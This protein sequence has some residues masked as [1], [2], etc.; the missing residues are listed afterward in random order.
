[1]KPTTLILFACCLVVCDVFASR[2]DFHKVI[3]DIR[4]DTVTND[5]MQEEVIIIDGCNAK[6]RY[7][8]KLKG[9]SFILPVA[10]YNNA[11]F[12]SFNEFDK[13]TV[14]L[15]N[16][17]D[18]SLSVGVGG[19]YNNLY[20]SMQFYWTNHSSDALKKC[21]STDSIKISANA[22][23][24]G[25]T[26][27]YAFHTLNNKIIAIPYLGL[28]YHLFNWNK[29]ID[30]QLPLSEYL[31]NKQNHFGVGIGQLT[32]MIGVNCDIKLPIKN[33]PFLD[34]IRMGSGYSFKLHHKPFLYANG[35]DVFS[36]GTLDLNGFYFDFGLV[37]H[38]WLD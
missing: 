36:N 4:E 29:D 23:K 3:N 16:S 25:G 33:L 35:N 28:Q 11:D 26:F 37:T 32:G 14:D 12:Y 27:G 22:W 5:F 38:L 18:G 15:L 10:H 19:F 17:F 13:N 24:I 9:I 34:Y 20:A 21:N 8:Y 2:T 6:Q 30:G 7:N 31:N 1:M